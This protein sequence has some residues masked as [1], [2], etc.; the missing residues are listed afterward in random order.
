MDKLAI[1]VNLREHLEECKSETNKQASY[2]GES[3]A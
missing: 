2:R 1:L 3:M